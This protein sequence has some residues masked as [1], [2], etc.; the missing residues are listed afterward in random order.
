LQDV[1]IKLKQ[2]SRLTDTQ[3]LPTIKPL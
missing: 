1:K 2:K 3:Q